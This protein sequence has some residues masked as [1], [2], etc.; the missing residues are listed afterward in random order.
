MDRRDGLQSLGQEQPD[1]VAPADA[2]ARQAGGQAV[3]GAE[4]VGV[5]E[6][7]AVLV[8]DG[9]VVGPPRGGLVEQLAEVGS[10]HGFALAYGAA[11]THCRRALTCGSVGDGAAGASPRGPPASRSTVSVEGRLILSVGWLRQETACRYRVGSFTR[12]RAR[13]RNSRW[14][15]RALGGR[16]RRRSRAWPGRGGRRCRDRSNSG[17]AWCAAIPRSRATAL[18]ADVGGVGLA[19]A[20]DDQARRAAT[21]CRPALGRQR[22]PGSS[23]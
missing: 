15:P 10:V 19:D 11:R 23:S 8:L 13:A 7:P 5:G 14:W 16:P 20:G 9:R 6:R 18:G 3:G 17:I 4:Q 12:S 22:P 2:P 21:P 1:A